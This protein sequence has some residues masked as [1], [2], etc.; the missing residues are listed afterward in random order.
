MAALSGGLPW[1]PPTSAEVW[2]SAPPVTSELEYSPPLPANHDLSSSS[3]NASVRTVT[4]AGVNTSTG[5]VK[6]DELVFDL[7]D[8]SMEQDQ[9]S[10]P[11][12]YDLANEDN[13]MGT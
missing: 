4:K 12:L 10:D 5:S 9:E 8:T 7:G 3:S 1:E 11:E 13:E 6:V 2:A